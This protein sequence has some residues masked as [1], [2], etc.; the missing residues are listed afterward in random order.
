ML[1]GISAFPSLRAKSASFGMPENP[2]VI[3]NIPEAELVQPQPHGQLLCPMQQAVSLMID[4]GKMLGKL[5]D[6][7]A[8]WLLILQEQAVPA[9]TTSTQ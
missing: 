4:Q 3:C 8:I 6:H 9:F 5:E 7:G 2:P 1:P